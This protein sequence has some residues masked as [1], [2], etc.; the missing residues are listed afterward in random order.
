MDLI[1]NEERYSHSPL[2][3]TPM[4]PSDLQGSGVLPDGNGGEVLWDQASFWA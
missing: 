1:P 2:L 4:Q 3:S